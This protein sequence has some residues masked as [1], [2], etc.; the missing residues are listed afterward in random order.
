[1]AGGESCG[2]HHPK[3]LCPRGQRCPGCCWL[4]HCPPNSWLCSL[5]SVTAPPSTWSSSQKADPQFTCLLPPQASLQPLL[6]S[7]LICGHFFLERNA[8][9]GGSHRLTSQLSTSAPIPHVPWP[10]ALVLA[11]CRGTASYVIVLGNVANCH[12]ICPLIVCKCEKLLF[13]LFFHDRLPS[14]SFC[15]LSL[16][17]W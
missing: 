12:G 2:G 3:E 17:L 16:L 13:I 7:S 6:P 4:F 15:N 1:M 9:T 8:Y 10:L 14:P 5:I 11:T